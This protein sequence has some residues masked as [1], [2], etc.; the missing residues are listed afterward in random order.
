MVLPYIL[1]FIEIYANTNKTY[2]QN[3]EVL[4]NRTLRVMLNMPLHT[5]LESL[6]I[7]YKM[8]DLTKP[9]QLQILKFI[10]KWVHNIESLPGTYCNYFQF[11][12]SIHSFNL[13]NALKL[14]ILPTSSSTGHRNI[15][16]SGSV[17]WTKY[18]QLRGITYVKMLNKIM[19]ESIKF[20]LLIFEFVG[21]C[22][23]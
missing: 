6:Y 18:P 19:Y 11:A 17:L 16:I 15:Q 9:H 12:S 14:Q 23:Y 7:P 21:M 10:H 2:L 20:I 1:Y 22:N 4:L 5:P 3:L 8:L 13:R